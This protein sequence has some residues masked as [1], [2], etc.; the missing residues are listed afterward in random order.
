[1]KGL[2]YIIISTSYVLIGIMIQIKM[3]KKRH[4][5][6]ELLAEFLQSLGI[7]QHTSKTGH[8]SNGKN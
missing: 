5:T 2:I 4:P 3:L 1:M 8:I 7:D 6:A